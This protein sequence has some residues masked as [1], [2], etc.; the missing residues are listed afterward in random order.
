MQKLDY[1]KNY[2]YA[3][4]EADAYAAGEN[5]FPQGLEQS[6]FYYPV[7]RGLEIKIKQHL[8]YLRSLDKQAKQPD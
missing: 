2:R 8:D 7:E 4:N 6:C 5:Y 3:H 1:G